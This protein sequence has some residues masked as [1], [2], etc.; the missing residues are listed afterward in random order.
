[1]TQPHQRHGVAPVEQFGP[2]TAGTTLAVGF[3]T[4]QRAYHRDFLAALAVDSPLRSGIDDFVGQFFDVA[5]LRVLRQP[6]GEPA[7]ITFGPMASPD[8]PTSFG[9]CAS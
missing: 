9:S 1:M 4:A 5:L 8:T 3:H 6:T 7:Q 2:N